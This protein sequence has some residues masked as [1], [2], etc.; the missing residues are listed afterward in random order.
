MEGSAT[1]CL[2]EADVKFEVP[3]KFSGHLNSRLSVSDLEA[4]Q[5]PCMFSEGR[6]SVPFIFSFDVFYFLY[7]GCLCMGMS[8]RMKVST[9]ASGE[10]TPGAGVTGGR[11]FS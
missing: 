3:S 2:R 7:S 4:S 11:T 8:T 6:H 5:M 1:L 9:E 10:L